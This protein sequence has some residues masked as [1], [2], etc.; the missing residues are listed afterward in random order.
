MKNFNFELGE[1]LDQ[2]F[3]IKFDGESDADSLE[4]QK[5]YST[6]LMAP[7]SISQ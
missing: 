2:H 7:L 1:K 4:T 5:Q 3:R 6:P